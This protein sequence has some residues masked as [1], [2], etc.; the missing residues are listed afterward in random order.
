MRAL[1]FIGALIG[2]SA[3]EPRPEPRVQTLNPAMQFVAA[4]NRQDT[5]A[6]LE[7]V[8]DDVRYMFLDANQL[9]TETA[10]KQ[11]LAKYLADYFKQAPATRSS[12]LYSQQHGYHITQVEQAFWTDQHGESRSQCSWSVYELQDQLI[13]NIWYHSS[14]SCPDN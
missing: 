1:L 12:I 4:Y 13:I 9:H 5:G 2:L 7:L 8:H 6:M 3:C 11:A 14:Y 10:G